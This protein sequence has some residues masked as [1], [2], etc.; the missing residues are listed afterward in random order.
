LLFYDAYSDSCK[1]PVR[2][3]NT[4]TTTSTLKKLLVA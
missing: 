3:C 2:V 1:V 4:I